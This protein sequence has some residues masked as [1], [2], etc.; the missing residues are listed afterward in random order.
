[1]L[2]T[3]DLDDITPWHHNNY[4][5]P[6]DKTIHPINKYI[7]HPH[8]KLSKTSHDFNEEVLVDIV[9]TQPK[10][11]HWDMKSVNILYS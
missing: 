7:V 3:K 1:M 9:D 5:S 10:M 6:I 4:K 8:K 11:T 2:G